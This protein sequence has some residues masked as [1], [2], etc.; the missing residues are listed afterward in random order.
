MV[1]LDQDGVV[2]AHPVVGGAAGAS[3]VLLPVAQPGHGLASV[4]NRHLVAPGDSDVLG[5]QAGDSRQM[6]EEVERGPLPGQ[7]RGGRSRDAHHYAPGLERGSIPQ[8]DAAGNRGIHLVKHL[9]GQGNATQDASLPG[10]HLSSAGLTHSDDRLAGEVPAP[11]VLGKRPL[12][13]GGDLSRVELA[14]SA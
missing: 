13:G 10:D 4:E 1:V 7:D 11:V 5:G 3:R 2:E 9:L 12:H 8:Q 6:L 14:Q